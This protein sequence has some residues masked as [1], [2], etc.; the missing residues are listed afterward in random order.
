MEEGSL[1]LSQGL[2]LEEEEEDTPIAVPRPAPIA[3]NTT[4]TA[5]IATDPTTMQIHSFR[6]NL[7]GLQH[8]PSGPASAATT[9]FF[10]FRPE[11][12]SLSLMTKLA[13][14]EDS[15]SVEL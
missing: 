7:R 15:P 11:V 6:E 1:T 12:S 14:S 13:S 4:S 3:T 2:P 10:F 9:Y 8:T 5:S